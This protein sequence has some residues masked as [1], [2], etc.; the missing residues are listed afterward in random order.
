MFINTGGDQVAMLKQPVLIQM[1][2]KED[3][4][5]ILNERTASLLRSGR[6][7]RPV[8]RRSVR[9]A[10]TSAVYRFQ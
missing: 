2:A 3:E 5:Q 8:K 4:Q 9:D 1:V 6:R 7:Y 10:F